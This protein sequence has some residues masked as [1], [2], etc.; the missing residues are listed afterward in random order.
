METNTEINSSYP[1]L[2]RLEF[3]KRVQARQ[4]DLQGMIELRNNRLS[5]WTKSC[6]GKSLSNGC[7]ACKSGGY[8]C[9]YAGK[10]CNLDCIYCAQGTKQEKWAQPEGVDLINDQYHIQDIME[11]LNKPEAIWSGANIRCIEYSGG[12]PFIYLDKVL[13]LAAF[14]SMYHNHIYQ[15][16]ITNGLLVTEEKLKALHGCGVKEIKFHIGATHCSENV[17][18]KI[19]MARKIM[20]YVSVITPSNPELKEF[21]INKRGI[22]RLEDSGLHQLGLSELGSTSILHLNK[23]NES[24]DKRAFEYFQTLGQL[25]VFDSVIGDSVTGKDLTEV[26]L[27]PTASREITYDIMQYA[28]EHK[29]DI[30]VN[31]CSQDGRH[32][33]RIQKNTLERK[34]DIARNV[35]NRDPA[36][37]QDLQR[38]VE[39]QRVEMLERYNGEQAEDWMKPLIRQAA[40]KDENGWHLKLEELA[41]LIVEYLKKINLQ[42]TKPMAK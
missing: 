6:A 20:D 40:R 19:E 13:K 3:S 9:F 39:E 41:E 4:D 35:E 21:L 27:A 15:M 29:M 5:A 26:Y 31:D 10:K 11:S 23:I 8:L 37:L 32:F 18:N 33:Q 7:Q 30:V 28:V 16:I 14:V 42:K 1:V 25:Y 34:I 36:H 17:L 2:S 38:Q 22:Q 24:G 12:E